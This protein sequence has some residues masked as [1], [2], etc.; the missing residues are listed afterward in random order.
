MN[1]VLMVFFLVFLLSCGTSSEKR[2]TTVASAKKET[3]KEDTI[4]SPQILRTNCNE[5]INLS[6]FLDEIISS[7][8]KFVSGRTDDE[9]VI[10]LLDSLSSKSIK[11]PDSRYFEALGAICAISDGYVSEHLMTITV[12]QY[13]Q[14]LVPLISFVNK[15]ECFRKQLV[16]GLSM[17]VSVG[18]DK[19]LDRIKNHAQKVE[20][21]ASEKRMVESLISD[22]DPKIFD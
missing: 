10:A 3:V 14:N 19:I 15:N 17:E 13:Y 4:T 8:R 21:T 7:P 22:I 1:R 12:T 16:W 20:L 6:D 18:G 2:P 11:Q 9:C 5:A